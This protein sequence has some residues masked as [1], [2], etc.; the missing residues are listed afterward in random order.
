MSSSI[1]FCFLSIFPLI[2]SSQRSLAQP[3]QAPEEPLLRPGDVLLRTPHARSDLWELA[4]SKGHG[5]FF[6]YGWGTEFCGDLSVVSVRAGRP[7]ELKAGSTIYVPFANGGL[8]SVLSPR[9]PLP[10]S[11]NG[12]TYVM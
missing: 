3:A 12:S 5:C 6:A 11:G 2:L 1:R 7:R 9:M 10:G 4:Q 8:A